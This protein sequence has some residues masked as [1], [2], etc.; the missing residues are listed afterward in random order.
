MKLRRIKT[1]DDDSIVVVGL[2]VLREWER[3]KE[4]TEQINWIIR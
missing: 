3:T 2:L 4:F 1:T